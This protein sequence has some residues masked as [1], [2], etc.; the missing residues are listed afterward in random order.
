MKVL[1]CTTLVTVSKILKTMLFAHEA[2]PK[3]KELI[4]KYVDFIGWVNRLLQ[5][6]A[7]FYCTTCPF[8]D[9]CKRNIST[10]S[11]TKKYQSDWSSQIVHN[12]KF[13]E[14]TANES[15]TQDKKLTWREILFFSH[16]RLYMYLLEQFTSKMHSLTFR[17]YTVLR[18]YMYLLTKFLLL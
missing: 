5:P 2:I 13:L 15:Q 6:Q 11:N 12:L 14:Q 3:N 16:L 10:L 8:L 9:L 1:Q 7:N 4:S 18:M 17:T